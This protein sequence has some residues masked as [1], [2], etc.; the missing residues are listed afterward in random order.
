MF[1]RNTIKIFVFLLT[2]NPL[3]A[4][5]S[6]P[7]A[8]HIEAVIFDC[9]GVLVD[10]EYLKFLAWQEAL[11]V[12]NIPFVIEE[13]MPVVG[14]SSK[15]ILLMLNKQKNIEIPERVIE[16]KND[17]YTVLQKEGVPPIEEMIAF[18]R[19]LADQKN[20]L[21]IKV[22]LASS[23]P[24]DEILQNLKQI[25]LEHA[26]D[27][28]ISGSDDLEDYVDDQGKNK[29]KPYIYMEAAKRLGISV[30]KCLV[31]EDTA[32]GIEA[33]TG[34]GMTAVAVPNKFTLEQDFTKATAIIH[35]YKDLRAE[36]F[37]PISD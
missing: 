1:I 29:P 18:A 6:T 7:Y 33:A 27:L 10:T 24:R 35:S 14:H 4:A 9:D 28:V 8:S 21:G 23:A 30:T 12:E 2:L 34:A 15:N 5:I 26:F 11:A 32:A 19:H 13:Y 37:R 17:R 36:L 22:G 16:R 31:F 20:Y 3:T 25:G